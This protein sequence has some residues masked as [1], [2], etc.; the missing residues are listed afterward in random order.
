MLPCYAKIKNCFQGEPFRAIE[1]I[2][3]IELCGCEMKISRNNQNRSSG[4][5][6]KND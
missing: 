3:L 2:N 6:P 1:T 5:Y 4:M